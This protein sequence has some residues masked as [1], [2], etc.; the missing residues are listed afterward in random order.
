MSLSTFA[1]E[2]GSVWSDPL[3]MD[4]Q[5]HDYRTQQGSDC[6]GM[7]VFQ[8]LVGEL[9]REGPPADSVPNRCRPTQRM[10]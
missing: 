1:Q 3:L 6:S 7:G 10:Y 4:P 5:A 8:E 2:Q 9:R